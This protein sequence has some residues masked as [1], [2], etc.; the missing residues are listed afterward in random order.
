M[1]IQSMHLVKF[2]Y[3]SK[4]T[5]DILSPS[6]TFI[7]QASLHQYMLLICRLKASTYYTYVS[8][9]GQSAAPTIG[10]TTDPF[11]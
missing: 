5:T 2:N 9:K 3:G 7:Y 6:L 4:E 8:E 1:Q 10:I 11:S